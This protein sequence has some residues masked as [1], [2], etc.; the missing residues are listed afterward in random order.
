MSVRRATGPTAVAGGEVG[1]KS[2]TPVQRG[3]RRLLR[4]RAALLG[5]VIVVVL[6]VVALFAP[7][8][9]PHGYV[10][11]SLLANY[12]PPSAR[13]PLGAD[14][15]G[16]DLLSRLIYGT[17]ISLA[18][19]FSGAF[20]AFTIGLAYGLISGY[21]GGRVDNIMM[22]VLDVLYAFPSLLFIILLMVTFKTGFGG[23]VIDLPIV[24]GVEALDAHL[25]GMFLIIVGISMTAWVPMARLARGIALGERRSDYV[26][27]AL[28]IG[29]RDG[30][31]IARHVLPG[32]VG[33]LLVRVTLAIPEFIATEAFL[34]FI[35]LG[36][37]PPTPSWGTMISEGVRT[38]QSHPNLTIF[39][40][41]ALAITM[42]AFNFLG[43]GLRDALDPH[44][45]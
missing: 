33:P 39:P 29:A 10:Q 8:I 28:A 1:R 34:S 20:F 32:V 19:A 31:V 12:A 13:Y 30:R 21:Y 15:L 5:S 6:V 25:G 18:V 37:T 42:L 3:F 14:F 9:A 24:K 2:A 41:L 16:R 23:G 27:A 35:G 11:G 43:D 40:G 7:W 17:R 44:T 45:R 38:L 22:R 36:A 26:E 4:N